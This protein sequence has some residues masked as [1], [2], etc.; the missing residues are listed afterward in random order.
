MENKVNRA[1]TFP[2]GY[3]PVQVPKFIG[4]Y[5][6][7]GTWKQKMCQD[8]VSIPVYEWKDD[9]FRILASTA[10]GGETIVEWMAPQVSKPM[11]Q[12]QEDHE[13]AQPSTQATI[14]IERIITIEAGGRRTVQSTRSSIMLGVNAAD[15]A[16]Q[17]TSPEKKKASKKSIK[18]R[19]SM[20]T[21]PVTEPRTPQSNT[22]LFLSQGSKTT[23]RDTEPRTPLK[24][25]VFLTS[26]SSNMILHDA[27]AREPV[28]DMTSVISD[29]ALPPIP[30]ESKED[31]DGRLS[32]DVIECPIK[33]HVRSK[34][35]AL[36]GSRLAGVVVG[37]FDE[38]S[39]FKV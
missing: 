22:V 27:A 26:E 29:K 1:I 11:R 24:D 9:M 35:K 19:G 13:G 33:Y 18:S 5:E 4:Y 30:T 23:L 20:A 37:N 38:I 10:Q 32:P 34:A 8:L 17:K 36:N 31:T 28:K 12:S 15:H 16:K 25:N 3:I 39:G 2:K 6:V 14:D 7:Q 21:L